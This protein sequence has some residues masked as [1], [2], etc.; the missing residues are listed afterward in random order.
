MTPLSPLRSSTQNSRF[1]VAKPQPS[2]INDMD[3]MDDMDSDYHQENIHSS[4]SKRIIESSSPGPSPAPRIYSDVHGDDGDDGEDYGDDYGDDVQAS[5]PFQADA[6][7]D[8]VDFQR[9]ME[10]QREQASSSGTGSGTGSGPGSARKRSLDFEP[11]ERCKRVASGS[12]PEINVYVD[13]ASESEGHGSILEK[14]NEGMSTVMHDGADDDNGEDTQLSTFSAVPNADMTSFAKLC[15]SP[16]KLSP[17]PS[18]LSPGKSPRRNLIDLGT[19]QSGR[20]G[21]YGHGQENRLRQSLRIARE[22]PSKT[23]LD[24]DL[25]PPTPR[26]IPTVTPRELE[27]LKSGFMSE[28]SSLR[29]TLSGRE[30][31]VGSLKQAV[32]DAERRVGEAMEEVR[33]EAARREALEVERAEWQRRGEEM[34]A[35]V[36]EARADIVESEQERIRLATRVEEL[37]S[38]QSTGTGTSGGSGSGAGAAE[39]QEAVEKVARELHVLYKSKHETKV[40]ALKKSYESRWEKRVREA[41]NRHQT[42]STSGQGQGHNHDQDQDQSQEAL[43]QKKV[44]EAQIQGLQQEMTAL[45]EDRTK[46]ARELQVERTEKGDLVAAVDEW[47]AVQGPSSTSSTTPEPEPEAEEEPMSEPKSE[48]KARSKEM[49]PKGRKSGIAVLG[50]SGIMGSIERMGR[51]Q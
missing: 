32:A 4:P 10:L 17:S 13:G 30:A 38:S 35:V 27:T 23:L 40:A 2:D 1:P 21:R 45:R 34:D 19:P 20:P 39:V 16:A 28:I 6:R 24:F 3:D 47:L 15:P 36:Q 51:N 14:W 44:L 31:E 41:E 18:K 29:A 49:I 43:A 11:E 33:N 46:M 25:P 37:E 8:T 5:S 7:D 50:R 48:V 42:S 22:S 9:L 26:S 12:G